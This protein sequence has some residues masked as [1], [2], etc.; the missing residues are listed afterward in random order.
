MKYLIEKLWPK[1]V[2]KLI[3]GCGNINLQQIESIINVYCHT[4]TD[5]ID[6]PC[7]EEAILTVYKTILANN[8]KLDKFKYC[9]SVSLDDDYHGKKAKIL[10]KSCKKCLKCIKKCPQDAIYYDKEQ[11][12]VFVDQEKCI[13]CQICKCKA[14][15][16][17]NTSSNMES[18]I[19]L[20]KKHNIHI[21]EIHCSINNI[22]LIKTS[23]QEIHDSFDGIISVCFGRTN[24][25]EFSL[26]KITRSFI[27]IRKKKPLIIQADGNPI[28]GYDDT[29]EATLQAVSCAKVFNNLVFVK[30]NKYASDKA[31]PYLF[32]SGGVN[33]C[34]SKLAKLCRVNYHG[35]ATGSYAR[36]LV[37]DLPF[38]QALKKAN[39]FIE[40]C[41]V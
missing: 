30:Y 3:L 29:Y 10:K 21:I 15:K 6:I 16:Y 12:L 35:I 24:L 34:T 40:L 23:F 8:Y 25:S 28:S 9:L 18:V 37:K 32:I 7:D 13:G 36:Q 2:F 41:K 22:K 27:K 38:D 20:A 33:S 4:Q 39:E 11:D 14:I 19:Y 17:Y 5:I 26:L 31:A 1:K